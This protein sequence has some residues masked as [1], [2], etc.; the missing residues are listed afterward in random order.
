[1]VQK[2][3]TC[4]SVSIAL[5][6]LSILAPAVWL[7]VQYQLFDESQYD[8]NPYL[9]GL[10][11]MVEIART[12]IVVGFISLLSLLLSAISLRK[13]P[14]PRSWSRYVET[15]VI[16]LPFLGAFSFLIYITVGP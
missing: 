9:C 3:L 16:A 11:W 14:K 13:V 12:A 5:F 15:T 6:V 1:M 8:S 10:V 2:R 4:R 7:V